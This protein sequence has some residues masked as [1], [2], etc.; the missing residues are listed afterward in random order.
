M[1]ATAPASSTRA[2]REVLGVSAFRRLWCALTL[3][4]LG[5]WLSVLAL[6]SLA[7]TITAGR[8]FAVQ[9]FAVGGVLILK[10]MPALVLG[11]LAGAVAD[12][13]DRRRTMIVADLLR[14][15]FFVSIPLVKQLDWLLAATFL[16]EC[17]SLFWN[18]AKEATV[19]NLV[20]RER[21]ESANQLSLFTTY[22]SAPVAAGLFAVFALI[23]NALAAIVPFFASNPVDLALYVNAVTFLVSAITIVFLREIPKHAPRLDSDAPHVAVMRSVVEGWRFVGGTRMVRGLA[24]GML[25]AF[26]AGGAVI[27]LARVYVNALGGGDVAY[28]AIFA[29]VFLGLALGMFVGPRTLSALSRRR[30][31]GLAITGAGVTLALV[32]VIPNLEI[33][34]LLS[35]FLGGLAGVAWV[36]GYTLIG[37]EV[38]DRV[39]GRTFAFIQSLAKVD[40]LLVLAAAPF[41]AG[42]IGTHPLEVTPG[43]VI[44]LDGTNVV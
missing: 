35:V 33:V 38:E 2:L 17:V 37:L 13:F 14:F 36:T 25:G 41:A 9:N 43:A 4:S 7:S 26:A 3:S 27:G 16:S 15:G 24:V 5:D 34:I 6:T 20:P 40:L 42:A 1:A 8:G 29:A 23:S 22:G 30:L 19:P 32:A 39:R 18:P 12:R 28:G 21:L 31:F 11:P 10:I 44:H